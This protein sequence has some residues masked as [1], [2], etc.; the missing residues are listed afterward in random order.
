MKGTI[1]ITAIF[2]IFCLFF[3]ALTV[4]A[5]NIETAKSKLI[6]KKLKLIL[7][8]LRTT[9][10][11]NETSKNQLNLKQ[12][13]LEKR[14][15]EL[16]NIKIRQETVIRNIIRQT[17]SSKGSNINDIVAFGGTIE[18]IAGQRNSFTDGH[19]KSFMN[20]NTAELDFEITANEWTLG[21]IIFEY[22]DGSNVE[23]QTTQ[24]QETSVDR[25]N[26][27]T[28]FMAFGDLQRFPIL[29][30]VGKVVPP[31][32]ISTGN[33][34]T[35]VLTIDNPIT[36]DAFDMRRFAIGLDFALPTPGQFLGMIPIKSPPVRPQVFKPMI[37]NM[38]KALG[39]KS[40]PNNNQLSIIS[41]APEPPPFNL[42]IYYY[43]GNS[44]SA[45]SN[46][47]I[48]TIGYR[49]RGQCHLSYEK[50]YKNNKFMCPWSLDIDIDYNTSIFDSQFFS[51]EYRDFLDQL[52][53]IP[54]MS[55]SIKATFGRLSVVA[56]WNSSL[57]EVSFVDDATTTI[58]IKPSAWQVSLGYQLDWNP[59]L[60]EIGS[61]GTYLALS[62]SESSDLAGAT[63]TN[64]G[65]ATRVGFLPKQR[66]L[67]TI[68]EWV[69]DSVKFAVEFSRDWDY[70][71]DQGGTGKIAEG[72]YS[73]I[74]YSF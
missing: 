65:T 13:E 36:V 11:K 59:W 69:T 27:D 60:E 9:K 73:T 54:G 32:G 63:E 22:D 17:L 5:A 31:F 47:A 42:G 21:S 14:I 39:Y 7:Q 66:L 38:A 45:N 10:I 57:K 50:L 23:F 18:S 3:T 29:L 26:I 6:E 2:I 67:L 71:I 40:P 24:G 4:H 61:Q 56:E 52:G 37:T 8:K 30:T 62:Y 53:I 72:L 33:P 74:T 46:H 70:N 51:V 58:K 64:T 34:V 43:E 44:S 15:K 12:T 35:D 68:G 16:E 1:P 25:I 48:T 20:L 19:K 49:T 28:A 41:Y 55:T